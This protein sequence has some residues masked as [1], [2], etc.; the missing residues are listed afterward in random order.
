MFKFL[1]S[2]NR[3]LNQDY[4][5]A[6]A[7]KVPLSQKLGYGLGTF[8]DMWGHWLYPTIAFQIFGLYLHVPQWQIGVA[9]LLNRIFDAFSDVLFG[10]L[11]DN[12]RTR[13][14]RRRPYMLVGSLLAGVGLP[15][16]VAI[17]PS[18]SPSTG[19]WFMIV[20]SAVY[21][22]IVS[23]FNM[24]FQS[25]GNELTPDYHERTKVFA[26]KNAVQK[27]PELGLFFFGQFFS[28][29]VWVGADS[30]NVFDRVKQLFTT[31]AAWR[32]SPDGASPNMLIG[33]Q[34]YLS[35]CGLIMIAAGLLSVLLVRERYYGKLVAAKQEKISIKETLWQTLKCAPFRIQLSMQLAYNIG[36]SMVGTLGL[37]VTIYYV[38]AGNKSVGN[39]WNF[40][41]GVSGMAF[42]FLGIP[43]FA[44]IARQLGKRHAM[45]AV[46][47][48]AV[49][50]FVATWWLYTPHIVWL[51][52]FAS[53]LIA[54]TGA[55]FWMISGSIG[56]DVMDY[57]ELENGRRREGSFVACGSWINKVG[58]AI[59][60]AVSF[61]ILEWVGFD[62]NVAI[63]SASTLLT[64]RVLLAAIPIIGLVIAM[65]AL[66][67]F[68][69]SQERMADIRIQLEARRGKV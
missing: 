12:T 34:V 45:M 61:F 22:P 53:G 19:F 36:L 60:A 37:A 65:I 11:S 52:V 40:W 32:T 30:S 46:L 49:L 23:C 50:I 17:D 14:G 41:M 21:L 27:I 31:T 56:A 10:W 25:L 2:S 3:K 55:G 57:D 26:F 54:F 6:S 35:I 68:P 18:W 44:F 43:V 16:L 66:A 51:Q 48:T 69:L 39:L 38:C 28:M 58:M 9:I 42:G 8:F 63:Q 15:F 47:G 20:S 24:P 64:I 13:M 67:R 7:D 29:A 59:G 33:A 62:S 5:I 4:V 1:G